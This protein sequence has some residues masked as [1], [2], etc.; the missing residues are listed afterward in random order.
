MQLK[1]LSINTAQ[2]LQVNRKLE[3]QLSAAKKTQEASAT[4]CQALRTDLKAAH[5]LTQDANT[6]LT[7]QEKYAPGT[8]LFLTSA[9][10]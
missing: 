6:L 3:E 7:E 1:E 9:C 10:C 8:Q 2:V 4:E 5:D